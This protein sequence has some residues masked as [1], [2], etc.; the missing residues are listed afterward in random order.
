MVKIWCVTYLQMIQPFLL[1]RVTIG[2]REFW[3][4]TSI[5]IIKS[6]ESSKRLRHSRYMSNAHALIWEL[7]VSFTFLGQL[8]E[9]LKT[10]WGRRT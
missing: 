1:M 6:V 5:L 3:Q 2:Y 8:S 10:S 9:F 7:H 4:Q